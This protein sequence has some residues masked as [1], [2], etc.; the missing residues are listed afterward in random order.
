MTLSLDPSSESFLDILFY[1]APAPMWIFDRES[2][3]FIEVNREAVRRYGYS[4]DEFLSMT[5]ADIRPP[6]HVGN[7]LGALQ[8][9][10]G[11]S[12]FTDMGMWEH[13]DKQGGSVHVKVFVRPIEWNSKDAV[14]ILARDFSEVVESNRQLEGQLTQSKMLLQESHHRTKNNIASVEGLLQMKM[15]GLAN[16]EARDVINAVLTQISS[17]R[18]LYQKLLI[19]DDERMISGK[20]YV[21]ELL[22]SIRRA[23]SPG[24]IR[25]T[26]AIM[27]FSMHSDR[28]LLLGMAINE[29]V[30][31]SIKYGF[32]EA[33]QGEVHVAICYARLD[34]PEDDSEDELA[35]IVRDNGIGFQNVDPDSSEHFGFQIL[36]IIARQLDG[37]F[38]VDSSESG[39]LAGM[40]FRP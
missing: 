14:I 17:I 11:V 36:R 31:N 40:N 26:S 20:E 28:L 3:R 35:L 25:L 27:E 16:K 24:A 37:D 5:I 10:D 12:R 32:P 9:L 13:R 21:E 4:R 22:V 30:S 39:V 38:S 2:L 15:T 6:E 1:D 18:I 29:M 19:E 34:G 8:R 33:D 23:M 7:L